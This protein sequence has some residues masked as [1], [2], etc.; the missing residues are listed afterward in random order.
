MVRLTRRGGALLLALLLVMTLSAAVAPRQIGATGD[1]GADLIVCPSCP[2]ASI[3]DAIAAAQPGDRIEV[4]GG[5]YPGG[6]TLDKPLTLIG[7]DH[8]VIDGGD[9]GSL[10]SVTNAAATIEG[11]TLRG[12]G[13]NHDREDSAIVFDGG[14]ATIV[15]NRIEDALFGIY[16]KKAHKSVVRDNVVLGKKVEI[17]MRGDGIKIWYCDDVLVEHNQASDGRDII[18]WYANR[19]TVRN[20]QFNR[21]RYGL[22]LMFS[23]DA[24]IEGNSLRSNTIGL[25]IMYSRNPV[26]VGNALSDNHGPSGAGLGLKDVDNALVEANRFIDNEI[27]VQVDESPRE[28]GIEN[29]WRDNVFAYNQIGIGFLPNVRHN[30]LTGNDFIDNTEHV[31][32]IGRGQLRDMTWAVDGR[33][34]YWSDYAGFDAN[35]DGIGDLPYRSQQLFES[36]TD[37][38][39][40]LKLYL[41][42]PSAM[43]VDFA[44]KAFPAVR[45]EVKL[46]DPSPLMAPVASAKLPPPPR[47]AAGSRVATG[48]LGLA[49]VVATALVLSWTRPRRR[50]RR[51]GR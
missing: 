28:M 48:G 11:F 21:E 23:D 22:H 13:S 33:G 50:Q 37:K 25:F 12:T 8:P 36:M 47:M 26:I 29:E 19:G 1:S 42:S 45:P 31:A 20:N 18:L 34:N 24:L 39:P 38:H 7:V 10:I 49:F 32:I 27:A 40:A 6:L 14:Q 4:R 46:E 5:T 15:G 17:A 2:I 41:F 35:D 16:L 9:Q 43:A 51:I 30:T 3:A 44:A